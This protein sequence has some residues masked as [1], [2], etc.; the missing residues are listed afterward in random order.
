MH[1]VIG[2]CATGRLLKGSNVLLVAD[3]VIVGI[4]DCCSG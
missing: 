3:I 2:I 1:V 4:L